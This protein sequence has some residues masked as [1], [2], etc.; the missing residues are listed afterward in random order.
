[1]L[2]DEEL[3]ELSDALDEILTK[4]PDGF[5]PG[6]AQPVSFRDP[7]RRGRRQ[8]ASGVADRQYLGGPRPLG[9]G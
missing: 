6:E 2:S 5:A 9:S 8:R 3:G 4:G 1:M 7:S